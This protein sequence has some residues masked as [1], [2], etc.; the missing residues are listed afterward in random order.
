MTSCRLRN[1]HYSKTIDRN[2][3]GKTMLSWKMPLSSETP[4]QIC[5]LIFAKI[6]C[7]PYTFQYF[8]NENLYHSTYLGTIYNVFIKFLQ[9]KTTGKQIY[10]LVS[11]NNNSFT[12]FEDNNYF[13]LDLKHFVN[14]LLYQLIWNFS[15]M[16]A[17][18]TYNILVINM[19]NYSS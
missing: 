15:K 19:G 2:F 8:S 9:I 1:H 17:M 18:N 10:R 7:P 3:V 5:S 13:D 4:C 14:T 16:V 12:I 6:I 11:I